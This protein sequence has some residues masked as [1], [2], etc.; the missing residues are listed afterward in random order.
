MEGKVKKIGKKIRDRMAEITR[1]W[2]ENGGKRRE[3]G[4]K[5][6]GKMVKIPKKSPH[7]QNSQKS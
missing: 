7:S 5:N 6:G 4:R 1:K 3:N 2:R